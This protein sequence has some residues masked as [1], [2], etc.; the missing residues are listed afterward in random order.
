MKFHA[1]GQNLTKDK[2][3]ADTLQG[4]YL[5]SKNANYLKHILTAATV[6]IQ[7]NDKHIKKMYQKEKG[8]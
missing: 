1:F 8:N 5:D 4:S 2:N 6:S 3:P 7:P